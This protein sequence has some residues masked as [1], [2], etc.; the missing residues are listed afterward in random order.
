M[1]THLTFLGTGGGRYATIYQTRG[2]GGLILDT[3]GKRIHIDP[4]PGALTNMSRMCIDPMRTDAIMISHCHPDHYSDAEVL[5]EGMCKGGVSKRGE[6]AGSVSVM[7]GFKGLGPRLTP[8]HFEMVDKYTTMR[9]GDSID[10]CGMRADIMSSAHSDATAVGFK[11]HTPDG[12]VAYVCDTELRDRVVEDAKG[13]RI[14][15]LPVTRPTKARIRCHLCTDD[16]LTF[17]EAVRPEMILFTHMGV[18]IIQDGPE[19]EA[20]YI[21]RRTGIRTVAADDMM[22]VTVSKSIRVSRK[23][24]AITK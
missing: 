10:V 3:S 20:S 17:A 18:R 14:L 13:S 5:I 8:Y 19:K 9:P 21:E 6:L 15:I 11:F 23:Q 1:S 4:G 22:T 7:E 12:T 16:V 2:T 24:C